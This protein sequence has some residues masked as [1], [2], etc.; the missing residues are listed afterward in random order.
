MNIIEFTNNLHNEENM[1]S[2]I[3]NNYIPVEDKK[4]IAIEVLEDCVATNDGYV[5]I[6][7]F[8]RDI[9]FDFAMLREYTNLKLSYDF[10]SMMEE[11]DILCEHDVLSKVF[12]YI[13]EDYKRAK[14]ILLY[15]EQ[16]ILNKNSIEA[17]LSRLSLSVIESLHT[18]NSKLESFNINDILPA[19]T[20][21]KTV[22][23][24]LNK[25]K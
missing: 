14:K 25:L 9:C 20:D 18:M 10:E 5:Q 17:Q 3:K 24:L 22:L 15:E 23:E 13:G 16:N 11:Y 6:D 12:N 1:K 19:G 7:R 8:K 4:N 2:I 21:M